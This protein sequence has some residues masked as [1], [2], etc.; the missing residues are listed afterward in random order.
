M[1]SLFAL[2]IIGILLIGIGTGQPLYVLLGA[3]SCFL[4]FAGTDSYGSLEALQILIE[5]TRGL[6]E[7]EVL[8]AIPFFVISGAIM[9]EGDI[10]KR[11]IGFAQTAFRGISGGLAVSAVIGCIFFAAIS[12]SSPVTVIAIGSIVFPAM[13]REGYR[14][15]FSSGLLSSAGSLGI[16]IPPSIPMI[17]YSIVDPQGL[18]DPPNYQLAPEGGSTDLVDLFIA[19]I[20]PGLLLGGIF[21]IASMLEGARKH[22]EQNQGMGGPTSRMGV[23]VSGLIMI[24][25]RI[26]ALS[27]YL[28]S[29]LWI[30]ALLW[31][32]SGANRPAFLRE[33]AWLHDV[34]VSFWDSFWALMLPVVILGG[35][36]SGMFTPTEAACVAVVYAVFVELFMY[37]SLRLAKLPD[38]L[39][40]STVLIGSLLIII[41]VAQG[42]NTYLE[43]AQIPEFFVDMIL[44]MQLSTVGF[45]LIVNVL[46]LVVGCFMDIMSAILIIVPLL[47]PI[48]YQLGIHP[49]HLAVVFIVNL[50]IGYLTP[51]LGLNL[52][53]ASTIFEKPITE[54][55][56][57]VI[58]FVGMMLLGLLAVTYIP[59]ISL[60]PVSVANGHGFYVPFPERKVPLD[61]L[62]RTDGLRLLGRLAD[63]EEENEDRGGSDAGSGQGLTLAELLAQ[64]NAAEEQEAVQC[65]DYD[66]F[67]EML[68][69]F[70]RL[71]RR[72]LSLPGLAIERGCDAEDLAEEL[73]EDILQQLEGLD[74]AD[75]DALPDG[76][77][78]TDD[79]QPDPYAA[80]PYEADPYEADPY[81]DDE[82]QDLP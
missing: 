35:I 29:L 67:E 75:E 49:I 34:T 5:K 2:G 61:T 44:E 69:D 57:A 22:I 38:V 40:E 12:G 62:R 8:L 21:I 76:D 4:L 59:T 52:F 13:I 1:I 50:E 73:G 24:M 27:I 77:V 51:P 25:G 3:L 66:N 63:L 16:L 43:Q 47:S 56:K 11:L 81:G 7:N 18:L 32:R 68:R 82:D 9:S 64:A 36:Y 58:P 30:P 14:S 6:S 19:G 60:G 20:G 37:R 23:L 31:I 17:V 15:N 48:A 39:T 33:G 72:E 10:S 78:P 45:L 28:P 54:T 80:D 74:D 42:F 41:A 55:I 70:G 65:L 46:L 79:D 26:V 71:N 53:V